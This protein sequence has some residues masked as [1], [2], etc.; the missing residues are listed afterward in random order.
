LCVFVQS[1]AIGGSIYTNATNIAMTITNSTFANNCASLKNGKGGAVYH[2]TATNSIWQKNRFSGNTANSGGSLALAGTNITIIDSVFTSNTGVR[3]AGAV[4]KGDYIGTFNNCSFTNNSAYRGGALGWLSSSDSRAVQVIDCQ[5]DNNR[6]RSGAALRTGGSTNGGSSG[7]S[8][9]KNCDFTDNSSEASVGC[10]SLEDLE[11]LTAIALTFKN[12]S[13]ASGAAISS[14][15]SA[16]LYMNDSL[17]THNTATDGGCLSIAGVAVLNNVTILYNT[18]TSIGGAISLTNADANLQVNG[19]TV[20]YNAAVEGGAISLQQGA[21]LTASTTNMH[22][23]T[24]V[25]AGAA[26]MQSGAT[27]ITQ[28]PTLDDSTIKA[29]VNNTAGCCYAEGYGLTVDGYCGTIDSG[30]DRQCCVIGE[31]ADSGLCRACGNSFSCTE[32]GIDTAA[33]TLLSGYWRETVS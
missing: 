26:I 14:D 8:L 9:L 3:D 27:T 7:H 25:Q 23:N 17:C 2:S 13:A 10:T 21:R 16:T 24:A 4:S 32:L 5:F 28:L 33:M 30:A 29:M 18:A 15:S 6:A 1:L 19:S 22:S 31:Y 20:A 12:N 11:K